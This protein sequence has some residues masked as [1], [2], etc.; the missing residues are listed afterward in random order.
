MDP[1]IILVEGNDP[2]NNQAVIKQFN[3]K[4]GEREKISC[5]LSNSVQEVDLEKGHLIYLTR[6]GSF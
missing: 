1:Y 5:S 6:K 2:C 3:Q 4:Q